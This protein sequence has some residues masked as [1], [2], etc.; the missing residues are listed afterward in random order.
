MTAPQPSQGFYPGDR[1][2]FTHYGDT[3]QGTVT[4]LGP[5]SGTPFVSSPTLGNGRSRWMHPE[6]LTLVG[7]S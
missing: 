1:V 5:V 6:S 2:S 3:L 4:R 7:F